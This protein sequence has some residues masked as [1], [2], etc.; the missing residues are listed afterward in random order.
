M[1]VAHV[2]PRGP[3]PDAALL[4]AIVDGGF[5]AVLAKDLEGRIL[6]WNPAAE[7][8]YGW[9]AAEIVGR[10]VE[11]L[12][13]E[14]GRVEIAGVLAAIRRGEHVPP[15]NTTRVTKDGRE[16][17][18]RVQVSPIYDEAGALC[19]A[20][21]VA[22]DNSEQTDVLAALAASDARYR[23]LVDVLTEIV[24]VTDPKGEVVAP[25]P[26][27]GTYTGQS[28]RAAAGI[29]WHGAVHPDD[30][31]LFDE[32]CE[33]GF[34]SGE[35][36]SF[37]AR[38][39]HGKTG[40]YRHAEG[41]LVPLRDNTN[42]V[43][44]WVGSITDVHN[45]RVR[46]EVQRA[47]AERFRRIFTANLFAICYG[48]GDRII[49]GNDAFMQMLH[50]DREHTPS[51]I[52]CSELMAPSASLL[53]PLPFRN[54]DPREYE[55]MRRDG[56]TGYVLASSFDLAPNRG[57]MGF[58]VDLTDRRDAEREI[59]HLALHD[60]LTGLPNRRLL[61]D[62]LTHALARAT[63]NHTALAVLFIDLDNFKAIND[64]HGHTCGDEV[65]QAVADRLAQ[66][67]RDG[68][69][70]ARTGG[71]EFVVVVEDLVHGEDALA[72]A[73]RVRK[74][75]AAPISVGEHQFAVTGSVGMA[76][77]P[78]SGIDVE[79]LLDV[80]DTA[81]YRAKHE[82]RDRVSTGITDANDAPPQRIIE[83]D[84]A[85]ALSHEDLE[86]AFQP[87]IDLREGAT[88]GAEAL[89]RWNVDGEQ[90]STAHAIAIAEETGII[91]RLSDW[92]MR[93]SCRQFARWRSAQTE[94]VSDW[95]LH[96]N[97]SAHDLAD[98]RFVD[99]VLDGV[100]EGGCAPSDV[101]LEV[102]ETAILS[103]TYGAHD[104]LNV[105]R[106]HGVTVAL[107]DFGTGYASLGNLRNVPADIVKI[108]RVFVAGLGHSERDRA[109]VEHTIDLA[110]QLG[111]TVIG[112]GV[113]TLAQMMI[114]DELGCDQIQ[115]YVL[116]RPRPVE[117]LT[118]SLA[119][120]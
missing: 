94:D 89:L 49:D 47:Q 13:P 101:C 105:L 102:T 85:R 45:R 74:V 92:I 70:V 108:D 83:Q 57:W 24:F 82:G 25:Q 97:V 66:M 52:F 65:L 115:G 20:S 80:A 63:R 93:S 3:V 60:P 98:E 64:R 31:E 30:R 103:D 48:E 120:G 113:E 38:L 106:A 111:L 67:A 46:A 110:H 90:M 96:I 42:E 104:R 56:T 86:L 114:L 29:G 34:L 78:G 116:A 9:T 16:I 73:E 112:E 40:E 43:V 27:W 14:R 36:F 95:R 33:V 88:V 54:A 50:T 21:S 35:Q 107:D 11:V 62:R 117:E 91:G 72:I 53:D 44:E 71:D 55:I 1:T 10:S 109:I 15:F 100:A 76:I 87:V 84:L 2:R 8:L 41:R 12:V 118:S 28:A 79:H 26:A 18:V 59:R 75:L 39:L 119:Y 6:S 61:A 81:M 19:G 4:A 7:A 77:G 17:P 69:T 22:R 37:A 68:D 58:A 5:D 32:Q 99:R 23:A 51:G